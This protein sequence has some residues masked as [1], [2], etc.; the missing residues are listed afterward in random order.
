MEISKYNVKLHIVS[1]MHIEM[2][3]GWRNSEYVNSKM[4]VNEYITEYMQKKWFESINNLQNYYFI[5]EYNGVFIGVI[6]VKNIIDNVGEGGIFLSSDKFENTDV[7]ARMILCFNDYIFDEIK[8]DYIYSRVK[9]DN[10]K[11]ISSSI[12]QGCVVDQEKSTKDEIA[13]I[14]LP[15]NYNNKTQKIKKILNK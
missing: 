6:N 15:D 5:T 7:V 3:R 9:R 2:I 14:L 11:A 4:I 8:L 10:K 1:E 12:A 13:F